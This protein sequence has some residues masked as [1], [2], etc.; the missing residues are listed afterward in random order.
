VCGIVTTKEE[1]V[2]LGLGLVGEHKS[3]QLGTDQV[4]S[5]V[6]PRDT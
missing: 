3:T 5:V 4:L 1:V 6:E 2:I